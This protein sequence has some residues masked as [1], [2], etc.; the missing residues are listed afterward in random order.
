M[1][2]LAGWV[3]LI[4]TCIAAVMTAANV[5]ARVTG[6]GFVIFTIGAVAWVTVGMLTDQTQLLYS[7]IFLGVVDV[8]GIW[9]W[10]GHRARLSDTSTA[11]QQNSGPRGGQTLFSVATLD[12]LTV[13]GEN[14]E[15]IAHAVDALAA[16]DGGRIDYLIIRR[17]GIGGMGETLHRLPWQSAIIKDGEIRT[18]LDS[19]SVFHLQ[20]ATES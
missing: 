8:I 2:D 4:T 3:A 13:R 1:A 12:G 11:E 15:V 6:W 10:L 20:R 14:G 19:E 16:C 9:R 7:N 18:R 5:S 17:G